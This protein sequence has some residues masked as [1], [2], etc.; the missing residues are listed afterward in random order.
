MIGAL[1]LVLSA[2]VPFMADL[3]DQNWYTIG[4]VV[5]IIAGLIAHIYI[6]KRKY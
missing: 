2:V 4:S 5:L 1:A 3:A 6:N